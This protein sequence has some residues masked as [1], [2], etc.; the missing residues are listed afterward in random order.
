MNA[1]SEGRETMMSNEQQLH[2]YHDGELS[3]VARWRFE[4]RLRRSPELRA[5]LARLEDLR[6]LLRAHD[7]AGP[8]P[9]LWDAIALGLPAADAR[10]PP[11]VRET[12]PGAGLLWWLKPVGVVAATAAVAGLVLYGGL[13]QEPPASTGGVV[14]W[15]DSGERSVMVLDDEPDTTIIWVFDGRSEGARIGGRRDEA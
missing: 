13:W 9:N 15:I 6:G 8:A 11:A 10:R 7:A 4:R 2:A 14:R 12:G 3:G 5:E 1:M